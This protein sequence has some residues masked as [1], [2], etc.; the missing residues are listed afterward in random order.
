MKHCDNR[1]LKVYR[2]GKPG[3]AEI[4]NKIKRAGGFETLPFDQLKL[5]AGAALKQFADS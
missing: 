1:D 4:C 3:R 2:N 5:G